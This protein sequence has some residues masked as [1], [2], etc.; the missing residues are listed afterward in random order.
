MG[1]L[2]GLAAHKQ[3]F[4]TA[5][6]DDGVAFVAQGFKIDI[7]GGSNQVLHVPPL[8]NHVT[9]VGAF[10]SHLLEIHLA[11][12]LM[13]AVAGSFPL[14]A[15][16]ALGTGKSHF[17]RHDLMV[18]APVHPG[19]HPRVFTAVGQTGRLHP[20]GES[21]LPVAVFPVGGFVVLIPR[22]QMGNQNVIVF[23]IQRLTAA[24]FS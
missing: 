4:E 1:L 17:S 12:V 2:L 11:A 21:L 7:I 8:G 3:F 22:K 5:A 9:E 10:L 23:G 19:F 15:L 14:K 20:F 13:T 6:V 18:Q 16:M 24:I